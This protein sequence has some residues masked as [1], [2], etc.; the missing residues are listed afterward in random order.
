M[1]INP[2]PPHS[3]KDFSNA[4]VL[5]DFDK[6]E[7]KE[8]SLAG[9]ILS[10]RSHNQL[11]F[12]NLHDF[13]GKIQ[14][15]IKQDELT[16][17]DT[18]KQ[19]LGFSDLNLLDIGD[20]VQAEGSVTKTKTGEIS[21]LTKEI[22]LLTKAVRPLPDK[23]EGLK[24]TDT[25]FR[26]RYL[27]LA[28][29]PE[30]RDLF[31]RKAK[32]WEANRA[33]LKGRGFLEVE[34]PVLEHVTGGADA[35]PFVTHHEALDEDF[36]LRIS[37]ELYL[38]R[39][40]GGGFEKIYTFGPVFRNEGLSDEHLQEFYQIEW[41]WAYADYKDN[42]K[43]VR[44]MFRHVAKKVYGRTQFTKGS[45]TFDLADKWGHIEYSKVMKERFGVDVFKTSEEDILKILKDNHVELPGVINRNRLVDNLWKLIRKDISGPAFLIN[46]PKFISPLSKSIPGKEDLTE[47]FHVIIAG[48]ELG[49]GYT[50]LNDPF[51]QLERFRVQQKARDEGDEEAQMMDIDYVEMLEYGMPPTSGYAHS[52]RLFWFLENITAREGTLF[53][54]MRRKVDEVTKE[55]YGLSEKSPNKKRGNEQEGE[56][57]TTISGDAPSF[58]REDAHK[59][60]EKHVGDDYQKIHALM[61]AH[62]LEAYAEKLGQDKDLWY[63]TGLLHDLDYFQYP[64]EHPKEELAWFKEWNFPEEFIHAVAAHSHKRTGTEP[65]S[66]LA[67]ALIATDELAGLLYAYSLMRPEGFSGMKVKSAKKKFKDKAFA[68]K[69]DRKEVNYGIE[70]FEVDFTNHLQFLIELFNDMSELKK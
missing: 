62:A 44:D 40:I 47:R 19:T 35:R 2:Y 29:N 3:K 10:I 48:S 63:V 1:G 51:D 20:F 58:T 65:R 39:L 21:L 26:R 46:E 41:Y 57:V 53:P 43:L 13:S 37:T 34:T 69:V 38:K 60:L 17:T 33:F 27:D 68:R 32:F 56:R 52:E 28:I 30:R 66:T 36:Y 61:V 59:L 23:H 14:L 67:C 6:Y 4:K 64:E 24:D 31:V 45:Y 25:I 7:N 15:Y 55:I 5:E 54:Q 49:N 42:M 9:R 70:K 12:M 16:P 18:K 8:V 22:K 50:E 11:V